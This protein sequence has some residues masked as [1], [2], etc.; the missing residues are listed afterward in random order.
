MKKEVR[1]AE[2]KLKKSKMKVRFL[3]DHLCL[4]LC[5]SS[6]VGNDLERS[7]SVS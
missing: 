7:M 6:G 2:Q 3:S 1:E 4:L 5:L